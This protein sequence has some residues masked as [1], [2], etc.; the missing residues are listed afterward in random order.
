MVCFANGFL[1]RKR[2]GNVIAANINGYATRVSFVIGAGLRLQKQK[3]AVN[4]WVISSWLHQY[5]TF[6]I[7]K[8]FQAGWGL[9]WICHLVPWRKSFISLHI[10]LR[11]PVIH[12]WKRNSSFPKRNIVPI[13]RNMVQRSKRKWVLKRSANFCRILILKKKLTH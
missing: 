8:E 4:A 1:D 3:S 7:L 11:K 13:M 12:R 5:R 9:Y 6:G 10:L 2:T